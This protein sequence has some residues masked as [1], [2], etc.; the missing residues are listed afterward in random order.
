VTILRLLPA[1][2]ALVLLCGAAQAKPRPRKPLSAVDKGTKLYAE[3]K[4]PQALA[5]F[6]GALRRDP[7]NEAARKAV[8]RIELELSRAHR[9]GYS[10]DRDD[11]LDDL[12]QALVEGVPRVVNFEDTVGDALGRV[13]DLEAGQGRVRQLLAERAFALK[14]GK[15]FSKDNE[16]RAAVRR[17]PAIVG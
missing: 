14:R 4:L 2:L 15:R 10:A 16:L 3:G 7:D 13:G 1:L 8:A 11:W 12:D 9:P 5:I 6:R 17:L